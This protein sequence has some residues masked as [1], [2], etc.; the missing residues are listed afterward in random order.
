[1][2]VASNK[3]EAA[4]RVLVTGSLAF[5]FIMRYAGRVQDHI[6]TDRLDSINLSF[7]TEKAR[8]ERGG[9]AGN[10]ANVLAMLGESPRIVA[11]VGSDFDKYR[12]YLDNMGVDTS[13]IAVYEDELTAT[14]TICADKCNNQLTFVNVGAMS[15][16]RELDLTK[17]ITPNTKLAIISPDDPVGMS[18]HCEEAR[19]AGLPFIYDPSFQVIAFSGEQLLTDVKGA[20]ALIVN[21]YEFSLFLDKTNL[22]QSQLSQIV[23][24]IV[25]TK[26]GEGSII[27]TANHEP[28]T[29]APVPVKEALDPTGAGDSF[30]GGFIYGLLH[31]QP[32]KVTAQLGSVCGAYAVECLGTQNFKFTH[33]EFKARY[34]STFNEPLP[35]GL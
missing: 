15:R 21:D 26:G 22:T 6:L 3:L 4:G 27:Y 24:I 13:C 34:E 23:E 20:K 5:D 31:D 19:K 17:Y 1:M 14:C 33:E 29:I 10:I 32:L 8:K 16:A 2:V 28:L 7:L 30:R 35:E 11:S 18:Q 9:C 12:H 25:V